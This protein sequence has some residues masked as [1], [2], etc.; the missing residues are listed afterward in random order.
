MSATTAPGTTAEVE[1]VTEQITRYL[2]R[3]FKLKLNDEDLRDAVAE[4]IANADAAIA[5]GEQIREYTRWLK[6]AA[7]RNAL[8]RIRKN[9]GEAKEPRPRPLGLDDAPALAE[10]CSSYELLDD[11]TR[12]T[13]AAA[14]E[15][16]FRKLTRDEQRAIRLRYFDELPVEQVLD[17]LGVSRN[18]YETLTKKGIRKLRDALAT[19]SDH[20]SCKSTRSLVLLADVRPL[21]PH[22]AATRDAHL[23]NCLTCKAFVARRRGIFAALPLPAVTFLERITTRLHQLLGAAPQSTEAAAG[24]G[25]AGILSAGAAKTIAVVCTAGAVTAGAC[26]QTLPVS[27]PSKPKKERA[28]A[29]A[30][31]RTPPRKPTALAAAARPPAVTTIAPPPPKPDPA[32]PKPKKQPRPKPKTDPGPSADASP[33]LPESAAP[34]QSAPTHPTATA[35]ATSSAAPKQQSTPKPPPK[36]SDFTQEFTP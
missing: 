26:I 31:K 6:R 2:R 3:H 17:K 35:A 36:S 8:D 23:D 5:R 24:T 10:E 20:D 12:I 7:W 18:R 1:R 16:A 14:L 32:P 11:S 33:F 25:A 28:A 22:A 9:E 30:K 21:D 13:D 15:R 19:D 34:V 4:A 27:D 29:R